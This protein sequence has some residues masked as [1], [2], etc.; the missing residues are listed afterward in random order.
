M[1]R[2]DKIKTK[3]NGIPSQCLLE[4]VIK[5]HSTIPS[6]IRYMYK[7]QVP[8]GSDISYKLSPVV[9]TCMKCQSLFSRKIRKVF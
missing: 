9:T 2:V 1:T 4:I 3:K 8:V 5:D 7:F 6:F